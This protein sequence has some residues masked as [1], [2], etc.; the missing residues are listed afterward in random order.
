[1][2]GTISRLCSVLIVSRLC[3]VPCAQCPAELGGRGAAVVLLAFGPYCASNLPP[4]ARTCGGFAF[5][6]LALRWR[7]AG[8][9]LVFCINYY[10]TAIY[11]GAKSTGDD[12]EE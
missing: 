2:A 3:S 10:T 4:N 9:V 6:A 7:A 5:V 11:S 8:G 1:M 12:E